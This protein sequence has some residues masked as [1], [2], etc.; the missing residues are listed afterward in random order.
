MNTLCWLSCERHRYLVGVSNQVNTGVLVALFPTKGLTLLLVSYGGS[1]LVVMM[2][3]V[4]ILF[5]WIIARLRYRREKVVY[6]LEK[7]LI[8]AGALAG[9]FSQGLLLPK[10]CKREDGLC[11]AGY[12]D[13]DRS[14]WCQNIKFP[15]LFIEIDGV[16]GRIIWV[17]SAYGANEGCLPML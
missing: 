12:T 8:M 10:K 1:S 11:I 15:V 3:A 14:V 13:T 6:T 4:G 2:I 9:M 5:V 17:S 7:L 16:R